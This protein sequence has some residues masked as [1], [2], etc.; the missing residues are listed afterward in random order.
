MS[1][2]D[3]C[4]VIK[5]IIDALEMSDN[6]NKNTQQNVWLLYEF[7][8]SVEDLKNCYRVVIH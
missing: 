4:K 8:D 6:C 3:N 1:R 2:Y 7:K 5:L